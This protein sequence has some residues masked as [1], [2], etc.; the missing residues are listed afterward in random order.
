MH[1]PRETKEGV[2]AQVGV[3]REA[4]GGCGRMREVEKMEDE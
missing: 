1:L 2:D 4:G 3:R